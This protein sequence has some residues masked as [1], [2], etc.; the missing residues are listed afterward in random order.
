M[1]TP[2]DFFFHYFFNQNNIIFTSYTIKNLIDL[3]NPGY[4]TQPVTRDIIG[5]NSRT[6]ILKHDKKK[7]QIWYESSMKLNNKGWNCK[8]KII[9]KITQ[10][11]KNY[12]HKNEDQIQQKKL[13]QNK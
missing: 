2:V 8:K 6:R 3:D 13:K 7:Y 10:N 4:S 9:K 1:P 5:V 12:N 11:K